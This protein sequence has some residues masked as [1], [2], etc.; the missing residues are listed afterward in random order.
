MSE[1]KVVHPLKLQVWGGENLCQTLERENEERG[2]AAV[3]LFYVCNAL[4]HPKLKLPLVSGADTINSM[5][6]TY[7]RNFT[8]FAENKSYMLTSHH[9]WLHLKN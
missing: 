4:L 2:K 7:W 5:R 9:C 3:K 8:L 1:K 6:S